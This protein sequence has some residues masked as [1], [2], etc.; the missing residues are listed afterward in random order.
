[1]N[2]FFDQG[3]FEAMK[4]LSGCGA[5]RC[6]EHQ[7]RAKIKVIEPFSSYRCLISGLN[8]EK[9]HFRYRTLSCLPRSFWATVYMSLADHKGTQ[10]GSWALK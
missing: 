4:T 3:K 2:S 7:F 8:K 9:W 6:D 5:A 10:R 1:M